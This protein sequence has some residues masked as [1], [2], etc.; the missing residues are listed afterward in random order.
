MLSLGKSWYL[1]GYIWVAEGSRSRILRM[2]SKAALYIGNMS[3]CRHC[4]LLH[5]SRKLYE[6]MQSLFRTAY[7]VEHWSTN[8]V[9]ECTP[10]MSLS[11]ERGPAAGTAL[12]KSR[13]GKL[14]RA[15][16]S[17]LCCFECEYASFQ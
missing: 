16:G 8:P 2:L 13:T 5:I 15:S 9:S 7:P 3:P 10:V 6:G 11:G 12:E 1:E 4:L 17:L 14:H